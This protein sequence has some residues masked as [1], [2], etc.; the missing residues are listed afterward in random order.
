MS[1]FD[2][3]LATIA[4]LLM[5][6]IAMRLRVNFIGLRREI[7]KLDAHAA[8]LRQIVMALQISNS[9]LSMIFP[10][11]QSGDRGPLDQRRIDS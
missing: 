10:V 9:R 3:I 4:L 2:A 11:V 5:A 6:A 8:D 7:G 1:T